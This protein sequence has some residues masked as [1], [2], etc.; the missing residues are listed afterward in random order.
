MSNDL[1]TVIGTKCISTHFHRRSLRA[2]SRSGGG[3]RAFGW[4]ELIDD[5]GNQELVES[6]RSVR[7]YGVN[8]SWSSHWE[9]Q[10]G[11]DEQACLRIGD[12]CLHGGLPANQELRNELGY[13]HC[14]PPIG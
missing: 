9:L 5:L 4:P 8:V 1:S 11:Q 12:E 13:R 14:P 10:S 2:Q 7:E 3:V 6:T